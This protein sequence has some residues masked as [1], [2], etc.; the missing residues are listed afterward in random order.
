MNV[1]SLNIGIHQLSWYLKLPWYFYGLGG[2]VSVQRC[3]RSRGLK[4]PK[5]R[6]ITKVRSPK[7]H[8]CLSGRA[9]PAIRQPRV[10]PNSL[11][12]PSNGESECLLN[13]G[14]EGG[15]KLFSDTAKFNWVGTCRYGTPQIISHTIQGKLARGFDYIALSLGWFGVLSHPVP[16]RSRNQNPDSRYFYIWVNA[17][18]QCISTTHSCIISLISIQGPPESVSKAHPNQY[19]RPTRISIQGPPD[20][21]SIVLETIQRI[22]ELR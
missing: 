8:F 6:G 19:P 3:Y 17:R 12:V 21:H 20:Y 5:Y 2:F 18:G 11:L 4:G 15:Y 9:P 10:H 1:L 13:G 22:P 14:S 16:I 7:Y